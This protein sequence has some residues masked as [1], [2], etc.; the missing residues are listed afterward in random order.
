MSTGSLLQQR[1]PTRL[2][3]A[4]GLIGGGT[5]SKPLTLGKKTQQDREKG[6]DPVADAVVSYA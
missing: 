6:P 3:D 2:K 4:K 1:V 5:L